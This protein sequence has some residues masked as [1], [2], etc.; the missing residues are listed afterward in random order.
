MEGTEDGGQSGA[1]LIPP[2]VKGNAA[3][4]SNRRHR[5]RRGPPLALTDLLCGGSGDVMTLEE[6]I[7]KAIHSL[8]FAYDDLRDAN[9]KAT[10]I[11]SLLLLDVIELVVKAKHRIEAI[12]SARK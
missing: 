3:A 9:S 11:E 6:N 1:G 12:Q 4:A 10:A 8:D 7:L 5:I 2:N